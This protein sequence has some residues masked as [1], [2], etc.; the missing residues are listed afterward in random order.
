MSTQV[1][2]NGKVKALDTHLSSPNCD[3]ILSSEYEMNRAKI[4][5]SA[6]RTSPYASD[7]RY[8][9]LMSSVRCL[10]NYSD[11]QFSASCLVAGTVVTNIACVPVAKPA[12]QSNPDVAPL[13]LNSET[14]DC[15]AS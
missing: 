10:A 6:G 9:L 14:I 12:S 4:V 7:D 15:A 1:I 5:D 13:L 11:S 2:G 3:H 8:S